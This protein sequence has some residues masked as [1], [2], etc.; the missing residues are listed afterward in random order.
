MRRR[1]GRVP[2][3]F[4]AAY[5]ISDE[6]KLDAEDKLRLSS[7]G[8]E[9]PGKRKRDATHMGQDAGQPDVEDLTFDQLK[10]GC[11]GPPMVGEF[12]GTSRDV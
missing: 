8:F 4:L 1:A 5:S 2:V 7:L 11:E 3:W 12:A 9:L 10:S 6:G